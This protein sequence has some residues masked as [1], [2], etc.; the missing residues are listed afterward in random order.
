MTTSPS[1]LLF[2]FAAV[3]AN[4]EFTPKW[5]VIKIWPP[6]G[7]GDFDCKIGSIVDVQLPVGVA[8]TT[9]VK[10]EPWMLGNKLKPTDKFLFRFSVVNAARALSAPA[11]HGGPSVFDIRGALDGWD[12][13][14]LSSRSASQLDDGIVW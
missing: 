5:F 13:A 9:P 11:I 4:K 3:K 8:V 2:T 10:P 7:G 1:A 12:R 14:T 6:P